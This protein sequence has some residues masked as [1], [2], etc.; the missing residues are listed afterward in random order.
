MTSSP[1]IVTSRRSHRLKKMQAEFAALIQYDPPT[2]RELSKSE[3]AERVD[4]LNDI[5][6]LERVMRVSARMRK[7]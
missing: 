6:S 7:A 1:F 5:D 3:W 4:L 2:L